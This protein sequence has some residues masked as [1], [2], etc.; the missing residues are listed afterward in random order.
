MTPEKQ[1][2]LL[3]SVESLK[4]QV[5]VLLEW[6]SEREVQQLTLPV[7]DASRAAL[8]AI[9]GVGPGSTTK[10]QVIDTSGATAIV[11]AAYVQTVVVEIGGSQYEIPSLI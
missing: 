5:N 3:K 2:E 9:T 1:Q 11:P 6:K 7:D 8:R 4:A 10:T